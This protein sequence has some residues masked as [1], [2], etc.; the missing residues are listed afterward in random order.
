M[1]PAIRLAAL[2]G[3][4][5]IWIFTHD[6]IGVGEDGPTHQPIEQLAML[7]SIPNVMV[8]RPADATETAEAWRVA[9]QRRDGPTA[10]VLTRQ[11]LPVLDRTTL[12]PA[13][14]V[15][16][17]GYVLYDPPRAPEAIL[18]ATGSEVSLALAAARQL[19]G[20]GVAV[21]VVSLPSWELF[22]SQPAD[23]R[24]TVLP[25]GIRARV[26]VE[27]GTDFGW[28]RWVTEDGASVALNHFGASAPG[29]RLFREFGFSVE[30]VADVV[31]QTLA[32]RAR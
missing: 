2:M 23:Y 5:V 32:A 24:D 9:M 28:L 25:P 30:H 6:S 1:K 7:R 27:A 14:R 16:H 12:A 20:A 13:E 17:G 3:L 21:R 31:R 26:S 18:I 19:D 10:L 29:D 22:S 11:K 4:P 8:L 15:R